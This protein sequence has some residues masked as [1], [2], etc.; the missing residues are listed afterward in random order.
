MAVPFV[1]PTPSYTKNTSFAKSIRKAKSAN[2][3]RV[4]RKKVRK[5]EPVPE[6]NI[7]GKVV[8]EIL[9]KCQ[10]ARRQWYEVMWVGEEEPMWISKPLFEKWHL[11]AARNYN[12]QKRPVCY[13]VDEVLDEDAERGL[14]EVVFMG[15]EDSCWIPTENMVDCG[16]ALA[17]FRSLKL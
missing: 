2:K 13:E 10:E 11:E 9:R 5:L 3:A 4:G 8:G 7:E 17:R 12:K 1:P 15:E 6:L 16:E 14:V